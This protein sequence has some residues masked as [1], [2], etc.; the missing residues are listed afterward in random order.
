MQVLLLSFGAHAAAL[1]VRERRQISRQ[2]RTGGRRRGRR[3]RAD[4]GSGG[5]ALGSAAADDP[6]WRL[7]P[8]EAIVGVLEERAA[9]P[10]ASVTLE[11]AAR[12]RVSGVE[13]RG[14]AE[15]A[16]EVA[17]EVASARGDGSSDGAS[18]DDDDDDDDDEYDDDDDDDD[19]L[20]SARRLVPLSEWSA[21]EGRCR[22][23]LGRIRAS[24]GR[25]RR[26]RERQQRAFQ[27]GD[28]A[29]GVLSRLAFLEGRALT[30]EWQGGA[31][32]ARHGARHDAG[33]GQAHAGAPAQAWQAVPESSLA[34]AEW[35]P[36]LAREAPY[37]GPLARLP[38]GAEADVGRPTSGAM[39]VAT[40]EEVGSDFC[41]AAWRAAAQGGVAL[42]VACTTDVT[43]PMSYGAEQEAPPIPAAMVPASEA[44]GMLAALRAVDRLP[45]SAGSAPVGRPS[46]L[47]E[48]SAGGAG[49]RPGARLTVRA[50]TIEE[51]AAGGGGGV[52][53]GQ[54]ADVVALDD[55]AA[56]GVVYRIGT[57][58]AEESRLQ[59]AL[60]FSQERDEH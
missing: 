21:V 15:A 13:K 40:E 47:E 10:G 36:V 41:Q 25:L 33:A 5:A 56:Q 42:L 52:D 38:S 39:Y 6:V 14:G 58:E 55:G 51:D 28:A 60:S 43:R 22:R 30:L 19:D 49:L 20:G 16:A 7:P 44:A 29:G 17:A 9:A 4:S 57:L 34:A 45:L 48:A 59:K 35:N 12:V 23:R 3:H 32:G 50:V 26:R 37:A 31:S 18:T 8:D 11:Q 27:L 1:A 2:A 53:E 24:L 54:M 46:L